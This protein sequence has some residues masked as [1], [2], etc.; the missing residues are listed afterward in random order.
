M[1]YQSTV[2]R[3]TLVTAILV[4]IGLTL[5]LTAPFGKGVSLAQASAENTPA[6]GA[7]IIA[8]PFWYPA[9]PR[10]TRELRA[11]TFYIED[12]D[13][14]ENVTFAYQWIANDGSTDTD[15]VGAS[16]QEYTLQASDE[17]MT[18]K[19]R[20]SFTDDAGNSESRTSEPTVEVVAEDA[21]IC[22]RTPIVIE[23]IIWYADGV[24]DCG[25]V[26]DD[27]LADVTSLI[28]AG[29]QDEPRIDSFKAGDFAGLSNLTFLSIWA[30][31]L[32]E[33]PTGVFNG[34]S[35]LRELNMH[36]NRNLAT[37]P[38]GIFDGL[39][40]ITEL[41]MNHN[42]IAEFPPGV[43]EDLEVLR[44]LNLGGNELTTLPEGVFDN[45]THLEELYIWD[46]GLT[47]LP[48]GIFDNLSDLERLSLNNNGLTS[49]RADLF[50]GLDK[51]KDLSFWNNNLDA[52]PDDI[53]KDLD[54]LEVLSLSQ[55][56][57]DALPDGLFSGSTSLVSVWLE[58]NPGSPFVFDLE[59][60]R[61]DDD[62]VVVNVSNAT[63]LDISITLEAYGGSLSATEVT[64]LAGSTSTDAINATPDGDGAMT[65]R[66]VSADFEAEYAT[67][68]AVGRG[69]P[70]TLPNAQN[71]NN[72][73]IGKPTISGTAQVGQ[74]LTASK[75]DIADP[76][77]VDNATFAYQWVSND[78]STDRDI[79]DA[80]SST[81]TI[82]ASELGRTIKV[83]VTFADDGGN[84]EIAT[85]AATEA[86][87][88]APNI[89]ATG[90]PVIVGDPIIPPYHS[91]E[92]LT[93]DLSGISDQNGMSGAEFSYTWHCVGEDLDDRCPYGNSWEPT[94]QLSSTLQ[95]H[96]IKVYVSFMD[97][98]GNV[99]TLLSEPVG[100]VA[101]PNSPARGAPLLRGTPIVG[102][103]LSADSLGIHDGNGTQKHRFD[104]TY[105]WFA[106][107][108]EIEGA[109]GYGYTVSSDDVGKRIHFVLYFKDDDGWDEALESPPTA[110]V[111]AAD[112]ENSPPRGAP[113]IRIR[114][115]SESNGEAHYIEVGDTITTV[116][117]TGYSGTNIT[118]ADGL[119]NAVFTYQWMR[120][121]GTTYSDIPDATSMSYTLGDADEGKGL[122]VKVTFT[123]D[124]GN[125]HSMFSAPSSPVDP[126]PTPSNNNPAEG[127]AVISGTAK[128]GETLTV[129][130]SGITDA[131]GMEDASFGFT[132][133]DGTYWLG[134][135]YI[136]TWEVLPSYVGKQLTVHWNFYDDM[137]Y[138]ESGEVTSA[139]VVA[140]VPE[141]PRAVAV[142]P[143]GTGELDVSWAEP[144]SDGGSEITSYT[145]QWK[146]AAGIWDADEDVPEA[147]A[148]STT[149]TI[150]GLELD[151][152]YTVRIIATNSI[153]DGA[154][155]D[156]V[157]AT[158]VAAKPNSPATGTPT[159]NGTAQ[160]GETLTADTTGIDDSDGLA[161]VSY[162]YQWLA[163]DTEI[164]GATGNAYVLTSAELGKAVRV[165][166]SFTD[167]AGNEESLTSAATTAVA[168]APPP[169]PDNVRAVTQ[170]SGAVE[171][172]WEAPQDATVTGYRIERS[173]ADENRGDQQ[174]SI[175]IPRDNHTLV[176]DTG[177]ADTGYTDKSAEKGV[178]YEYRVSARNE[179]GAGE[180]SDWV[181]AGPES[182]SNSP[183]TG[184]PTIRG[185]AQ[186]GETLTADISG[187]ADAD[188]L[189]NVS[190]SYQ[191]LSSRD[192]AIS[193]ATGETY[194]L[195]STDFGKIIK[196]K[197]TFTDDA[198]N[199]ETL[200]SAGTAAVVA[201]ANSAGI[202]DRTAQVRETILDQ[203]PDT[204]DCAAVTDTDL[205]GIIRLALSEMGIT[206]LKSGDFSGLSNLR[207]L[208]LVDNEL[209]ALS[210]GIF[211][212]LTGLQEL[213]LFDNRISR[214]PDDIFDD[215]SE[216]HSLHLNGNELSELPDGIF[217]N[218]TGLQELSLFDNRISRLPDDIFDDLSEL[219]SLHLNGNEL[220]ELPDGIF[221]NLTQLQ[222]L[223]LSGNGLSE[224]PDDIFDNLT[225]LQS[226]SLGD[227]SLSELPDGAFDNLTELQWLDLGNN[228][229][230]ELPGGIFDNLTRLRTLKLSHNDLSE[231]PDGIFDNL[232]EL[233]ILYLHW[234]GLSELP[235]GILD[236]V[237]ALSS[238]EL[239]YNELSE[240]P[241][242]LFDDLSELQFLH[243]SDNELSVLPDRA[244]DSLT[245]LWSLS[246]GG[247]ELSALPEDVFVN[248]AKLQSLDLNSNELSELPDG[249]F[250]DLSELHSL[251]LN[252]NELSELPDGIFD[253][254]TKLRTLSVDYNE[255][256]E[257]PDSVFDNLSELWGLSLIGNELS[258][259][260]DGIFDNLANLKQLYLF[261]N[262]LSELPDR[263]FYGLA[264]LDVLNIDE[265]TGSPF[266]FTVELERP[267][268]NTIA[269][270]VAQATPFD[271]EVTLSAEGGSLSSATVLIPAGN[272]SSEQITVSP[273]GAE[274]VAIS[275]VSAAFL[276]GEFQQTRGIQTGLGE[277]LTLGE[278][279]DT[280][281]PATGT[282]TISGT[283]QVGETLRA[284]TADIADA[285]GLTGA[286]FRYQWLGSRDTEIQGATN[287]TYTLV[288]DDEGKT[289]KVRV[290]FTDDGGNNETLTSAPTAVV[291][292]ALPPPPDNV[293]AVTQESGAVELT[294]E[295][296]QDATVTG[297]RIERSR[298]DENRGGQQRSDGRPRDNHTLVEDT[299]SADTGY[300][301]K[302]AEKGVEY[303]YR[304]SARNEA[305]AGESSDWVRAGPESVSNSPAT[306]A[307]TI[308]GT[309]QVGQTLTA[310]TSG[311]ADAEG[312]SGETFTYQWVSGDGTTDTDI[313]D[314]ERATGSTLT[315]VAVDKGKAIKVRVT[316][317]DGGGNEET[318]TSAP[319][320]PVWGDGPPGAPRNLTA[321]AGNKEITL[322][323]DPP[324]DNG[325]AP[326]TRYR[327]EWRVDGKDYDQNHW[328]TA[329]STTYTTNDQANLANG[330]KYF[331]RVKAENDD[332]NSYGPYG[333]ASEEVSA[334]P[335]SG[336]AVD[337]GTPVLS[338]TETLHHG[339][340]QLDWQDIE[341]AGWYVV[342]YYHVEDG[343][344]LYLPAEGV[345]IAFHGSSAVVSNLHGLQWLRVGAASC[346][347]ASEWS[348]IE[349]L[350]GTKES[351]W[352]GVPV[353]EVE[354]GDQTEPCPVVL[355]TPVLSDTETLHH[356]MVQLD[357]QDIEDAGWYVVQYYHVEDG[358]W[359]DLPAEGVDI[360]FHGS[361]AVV[362]NLHGLS[363]LRVRAMSCAGES[364][365][366]QIEQLFGTKASDWKG[367]PVP[368]VAEGD[369]IAPCDE[370]ADTPE[371]SPATGAPAISGTVQ[372]GETLTA[373]TSGIADSDGLSNVQYEYQW[374]A[375]DIAI[376]GATGSTYTLTD[377][378]ESK[379]ITVQ[380]S[381]TDD[382]G[383]D[384]SLTSAATDAVTA[385]PTPNSPATGVLAITGAAQVG[386]TLTVYSFGIEDAD[387]LTNAVFSYQ[388][389][390]NDG[391]SNS[392]IAGAT[393]ATYTLA[394]ADEGKVIQVRVSF[395]DD[396]GNGETLTS[397]ATDSV[398]AAPAPNTPATGAPTISGTAQVGEMLEAHTSGIADQDGLTNPVFTY[399]WLA[400]D[401]AIAGATG[402]TYTLI[403]ADEGKSIKVQVSFPDDAGNE[404]S[405]TSAATVA[406]STAPS[407]NSPETG[408]PT[409]SGTA[410]V[411][412]TL[413]ADTSSIADADGME[414]TVLA[415]L[416]WVKNNETEWSRVRLVEYE[417]TYRIEPRDV[418]K[419]ITVMVRFRDDQDNM[420]YRE[421][422]PTD[423]VEA[424]PN[425]AA[426]GQ[427]T[428]IGIVRA[429]ETLTADTSGIGDENGLESAAFAYQ[430]LADQAE[431]PRATGSTYYLSA[432][433]ESKSI[434]LRVSFT[435]DGGNHETA[436]SPEVSAATTLG[437]PGNLALTPVSVG[438]DQVGIKVSWDPPSAT[439]GSDVS[440]Y[441]VQWKGYD[442]D[443][444]NPY[445]PRTRQAFVKN[446]PFTIDRASHTP[447][448]ELTIRVAAANGVWAE[449]IRWVPQSHADLELW[450][451]MKE[452]ADEK[453][454]TFPWVLEAWN[455][456]EENNVAV[457]VNP[458]FGSSHY[459]R[460]CVD[461][462]TDGDDGL[463]VCH[464]EKIRI[465]QTEDPNPHA[466]IHE[467]AHAYTLANRVTD[468]PEPL[469]IAHLYFKS[470]GLG[471]SAPELYADV[472][473]LLTLGTSYS[474]YWGPCNG[475]NEDRQA[476][477][478]DVVRSAANGQMPQWFAD[479]YTTSEGEPDLEGLWTDV[480]DLPG[481]VRTVV[482]YQLRN[483]FGGYCDNRA[484]NYAL[485]YGHEEALSQPW[486]DGGCPPA[487]PSS[488]E[489]TAGNGELT[490]VWNAPAS[491]GGSDVEGY[492][493]QWKSGP[494]LFYGEPA[495][496]RL[497]VLD[498]PT[499]L[500]YTI[501]GLTNGVEYDVR[502][503]A[504]NHIGA[505]Q[506][507]VGESVLPSEA[508]TPAIPENT[509]ATG[510]PTISGTV[511]VGEVL[512]VDTSG[513]ADAD[514]LSNVQYGYQWLADD[515]D[516]AGASGFAYTLTDSEE[517]KAITVQVSFTDDADNEETLTS[518]ATAAVASASTPNSP[519]T[520]S[521]T[522]TG[523]VQV[524]E[525]LTGNTS[526]IADADGLSDVQYEY[527]WLADDSEISGRYQLDLH[528]G[529]HRRGHG[530]QGAGELHGRC[531]QRGDNDQFSDRRGGGSAHDQHSCHG[532]ANHYWDRSGGRDADGEHVGHRR[533]E[534]AW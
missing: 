71:D 172:T 85:S 68:I 46:N 176:E 439:G 331:F 361:S 145:V 373:N 59:V 296:P 326:A 406:V 93:V 425:T 483:G 428:I 493:V 15:I 504:Y 115:S 199:S 87:V 281:T 144:D 445:Q 474:S 293:R 460:P 206:T 299:G 374:L 167:D 107:G 432:A 1:T 108:T 528:P 356:G 248:L 440:G 260:P 265:N 232:T 230:S 461:S 110:L 189:D 522:I 227:N 319:T 224:L 499:T 162:N 393:N 498:S 344:W 240:L 320:E 131:D 183:A 60:A 532:S 52:L 34:L 10:V 178:E 362:S 165:R 7:P 486:R 408:T 458:N 359:L 190:F 30:T 91:T 101:H 433:D 246:V 470:L 386:E 490:L 235:D 117:T 200:T 21:G 363:W 76:D 252:G 25:F 257:L 526:G 77:G 430:W 387:G 194:T 214:L 285:D 422:A 288:A 2:R 184:A 175:G 13:G 169:P 27:H 394:A 496:Q 510:A 39:T 75:S 126:G 181:R 347:G 33:L 18:I 489:V 99:E 197:V 209:S 378:E 481:R 335:T 242:G 404:E 463:Q 475:S 94:Y 479:T 377:S 401:A 105:Q 254:L 53:F 274:P 513:I 132:W 64:L 503:R 129:D 308:S 442:Q 195:V 29:S 364:E 228:D 534:R 492:I 217:D 67:G 97:D 427:P 446:T 523:T 426:S 237:T 376:A 48:E 203:L 17:G 134:I 455:Y 471:C 152:E 367:V 128:V 306:G 332:G 307:P 448:D 170:N 8:S 431:I 291:S 375:D 135:G 120:G 360:A 295:A 355:G 146:K 150:T 221:D 78:G 438:T 322:S 380:V 47:T 321:T 351:D 497:V 508:A 286:T 413:T 255:L 155:S 530:H 119:T 69:G 289:I 424:A 90:K 233:E 315:L 411:G 9:E 186:V 391:S 264:S 454:T 365:W 512:E 143:G 226:L 346:D 258:E 113:Q 188:G 525:T 409:I 263:I 437:E 488:L 211:D 453:R 485:S 313:T 477:A 213:S 340:V 312:L 210:D 205:S 505:G 104:R 225:E 415:F 44:V 56:N 370:D 98:G 300:T 96:T 136:D 501:S 63:P 462:Y 294:W 451:L 238:L 231:L 266:T 283:A 160:V 259:L 527:R 516:I 533:R 65:V 420:E 122:K 45:L 524:G 371:N 84:H 124:A 327:I 402:S 140:T 222:S 467:M 243:L 388:W 151:V 311:I 395:P 268:E 459:G 12:E 62:T 207:H 36:T 318:L 336:S 234:N 80:T 520:G 368:E 249:I 138:H 166:V 309:A 147:T 24:R 383:N 429:G 247:N 32:T 316:F 250:D 196:V 531:G 130:V 42:A 262:K 390:R 314:I 435:D 185:T 4:A 95:G 494:E 324:D 121:D 397:A 421:S 125:Q 187:I 381:F 277:H 58:D 212:D 11:L 159:I 112:S 333:P 223:S 529:R 23:R 305:G 434:T 464:T 35:R 106:D 414:D 261:S 452:Y 518:A 342:Q 480:Q 79:A 423:T 338:D 116:T 191:W 114:H 298:A 208:N 357:W 244:F 436:I 241:D 466:I 382:T 392:D 449:K 19:V 465:R 343:E 328:G 410:Q 384:E 173:R 239:S 31:D 506:P 403:E 473:T 49:L 89:P 358:E 198:G 400:D 180:S 457:E 303:E 5:F 218:L 54:S 70:L 317:T 290:T 215:L 456:M 142:E 72:P 329:R 301:D 74:T 412:E 507:H 292:A 163:D 521:P 330:V 287:V 517:S 484:V 133:T 407:S 514:G 193:G 325:N 245:K 341:D 478:F 334:T 220:S 323:W 276:L 43:F 55:N 345:D 372:V 444:P 267:D 103:R 137:G 236:K 57:F 273:N 82:T 348:Q 389:V 495:R 118:D 26:T 352:E 156:E 369:E 201:S 405:L 469:A 280:D 500:A 417:G 61:E 416:W 282:P 149:H 511:Q 256:S 86:V 164:A 16:G 253:N 418:G 482:I 38:S 350:Y 502:V 158:T 139:V 202:C 353:P 88:A 3:L 83:L 50:P 297:Y 310:D 157:T 271:M 14:M 278:D 509:P 81:Y 174:R 171:L 66:V 22:T 399:Q 275:V 447:G 182:V 40:L 41:H 216:L 339:M 441:R 450:L 354:E 251:H 487:V 51:L 73:A 111:V 28:F 304:V 519:A 168:A 37:L 92:A 123:D 161:D 179:A 515:T 302:S 284:D 337:L 100:P 127:N 472:L 396:E 204:S 366:S 153:G 219:H 141:E 109:T 6:T 279:S 476:Q 102:K 468:T 177:S 20:V 349:E 419:T 229:L 154:A 192:T 272:V 398:S 443:Y 385:E 379:A 270:K 148:T 491:D 269:L